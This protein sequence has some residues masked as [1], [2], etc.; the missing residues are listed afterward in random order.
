M[1]PTQQAYKLLNENASLADLEAMSTEDLVHVRE[2]FHHFSEL[3][4][5]RIKARCSDSADHSTTG[6]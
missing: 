3:A 4:D 1:N 5:S 2:L 6:S